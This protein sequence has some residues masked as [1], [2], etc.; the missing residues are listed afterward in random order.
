MK[1]VMVLCFVVFIL[2]GM[3]NKTV[4]VDGQWAVKNFG[5]RFISAKEV[6]LGDLQIPFTEDE[7]KYDKTSWLI[8]L[9]IKGAWDYYLVQ[10]S[11]SEN[12]FEKT[13]TLNLQEA[14]CFVKAMTEA[15]RNL[16]SNEGFIFLK[17]STKF[18]AND[19]TECLKTLSCNKDGTYSVV[20]L[21]KDVSV[22]LIGENSTSYISDIE[23][24]IS[25][26]FDMGNDLKSKAHLVGCAV[27]TLVRLTPQTQ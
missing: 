4:Y 22:M 19:G 3:K 18:L 13:D 21:P 24:G 26:S 27:T 11:Y 14:E 6:G 7:L 20:N 12:Q 15:G 8:P 5:Q 1:K 10:Y 25:I 16:P 23:E 9:K 2:T 17:T